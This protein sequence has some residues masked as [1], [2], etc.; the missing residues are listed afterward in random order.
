MYISIHAP[1]VGS[2]PRKPNTCLAE[3]KFQSTLPVWGATRG[4]AGFSGPGPEFQSTL[5]VWG[6]TCIGPYTRRFPKFQSTLPVW[7]ATPSTEHRVN[8]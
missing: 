1:R 7:G 5:P 2:D 8:A 6:A 4:Q 3:L